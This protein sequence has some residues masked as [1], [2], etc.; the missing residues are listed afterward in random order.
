MGT[1]AGEGREEWAGEA[2]LGSRRPKR[3]K[4]WV[5]PSL[6]EERN[7]PGRKKERKERFVVGFK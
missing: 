5:G 1:G 7:R 4:E 2:G 6:E 3:R